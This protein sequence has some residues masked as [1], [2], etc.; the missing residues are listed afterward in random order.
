MIANLLLLTAGRKVVVA[1]NSFAETS[2]NSLVQCRSSE[3]YGG[4]RYEVNSTRQNHRWEP[5][6]H[7]DDQSIQRIQ[8]KL[9]IYVIRGSA[10]VYLVIYDGYRPQTSRMIS[11]I[12]INLVLPDYYRYNSTIFKYDCQ[13]QSHQLSL[14]GSSIL[15]INFDL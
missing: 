15:V 6:L 12:E 4:V 11:Y 13:D 7:D 14:T 10:S 8:R 3:H 9:T 5:K 1:D 2:V